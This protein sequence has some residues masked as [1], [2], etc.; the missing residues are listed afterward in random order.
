[1]A[2]LLHKPFSMHLTHKN[3]LL[4][5]NFLSEGDVVLTSAITQLSPCLHILREMLPN[6]EF[7]ARTEETKTSTHT[8]VGQ[9]KDVTGRVDAAIYAKLKTAAEWQLILL[10]CKFPGTIS[11]PEWSHS[12][13][14]GQPLWQGE[15]EVAKPRRSLRVQPKIQHRPIKNARELVQQGRKYV[16]V[17]RCPLVAFFDQT[18]LVALKFPGNTM[19]L[20]AEAEVSASLFLT[21]KK[22]RFIP[23]QLAILME[24]LRIRDNGR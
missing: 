4:S 11:P 3:Q 18:A 5:S 19:D 22:A 7:D 1:M 10:E 9:K 21:T 17:W 23:V 6:L 24:G 2:L 13:A 8:I 12:L 14:S 16:W 20:D 15:T